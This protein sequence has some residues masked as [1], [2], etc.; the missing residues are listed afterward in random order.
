[1]L[2]CVIATVKNTI[3]RLLLHWV[4]DSE[5]EWCGIGCRYKVW[6]AR[7]KIPTW[8]L[9]WKM[10]SIFCTSPALTTVVPLLCPHSD[11]YNRTKSWNLYH[12]PHSCLKSNVWNLND[13]KIIHTRNKI[14]F[15]GISVIRFANW[16]YRLR[17]NIHLVIRYS[18]C[19]QLLCFT[20]IPL[21]LQTASTGLYWCCWCTQHTTSLSVRCYQT[22]NL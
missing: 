14:K 5:H 20:S 6:F 17:R 4:C 16:L 2:T 9:K 22:G 8:N 15:I 10:N 3:K 1:M 7:P 19:C 13:L 12:N 21:L 18:W 11:S